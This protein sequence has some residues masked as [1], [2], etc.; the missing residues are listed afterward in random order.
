MALTTAH[1]VLVPS[2]PMS[3][4]IVIQGY[5]VVA[6]TCSRLSGPQ[7][8]QDRSEIEVLTPMEVDGAT[9]ACCSCRRY[10]AL[11]LV[12]PPWESGMLGWKSCRIPAAARSSRLSAILRTSEPREILLT[13]AVAVPQPE[14]LL[15]KFLG[16]REKFLACQPM[17]CSRASYHLWIPPSSA[18][19]TIISR[20]GL[21]VG[22]RSR[23]ARFCVCAPIGSDEERVPALLRLCCPR[24]L[25]LVQPDVR[26]PMVGRV[27][28]LH[29]IV[30]FVAS[31]YSVLTGRRLCECRKG[32]QRLNILLWLRIPMPTTDAD[33]ALEVWVIPA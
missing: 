18:L 2:W 29:E 6:V 10:E 9:T 3:W 13:L 19:L 21:G 25:L 12:L 27:C 4:P 30:E 14:S 16:T 5:V 28:E 26:E 23:T 32:R 22:G 17:H 33:S 1:S 31:R 7:P 20:I 11:P 24:L 8:S 15:S